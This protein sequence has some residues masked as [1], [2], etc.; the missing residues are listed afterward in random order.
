MLQGHLYQLMQYATTIM[1]M[2]M[3]MTMTIKAIAVAITTKVVIAAVTTENKKTLL[4]DIP[5]DGVFITYL[6]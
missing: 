4:P 6:L 3:T 1:A 2:T 5:N